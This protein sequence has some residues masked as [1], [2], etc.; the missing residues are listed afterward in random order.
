M[1]LL[2]NRR[3]LMGSHVNSRWFNA[4]AWITAVIV[5]ALSV[6]YMVQLVRH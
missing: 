4:A 6:M 3:D 5:S 2:I 1:L